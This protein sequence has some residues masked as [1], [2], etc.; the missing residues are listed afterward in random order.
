MGAGMGNINFDNSQFQQIAQQQAQQNLQETQSAQ[1]N[2]KGAL[3]S[4]KNTKA[5]EHANAGNI[6]ETRAKNKTQKTASSSKTQKTKKSSKSSRSSSASGIAGM[7]KDAVSKATLPG[8]AAVSQS[9]DHLPDQ[10]STPLLQL[11][12]TNVDGTS[13]KNNMGTLALLGLVLTMLA[14]A[15]GKTWS[16]DFLEQNQA[17]QNQVKLAP[18]IGAAIRAQANEQAAATEAQAKQSL[19]SGITNICSFAAAGILGSI[20][21]A[22]ELGGKLGSAVFKEEGVAEEGEEAGEGAAAAATRN[23]EKNA[24][25]EGEELSSLEQEVSQKGSTS[26]EV[27]QQGVRNVMKDQENLEDDLGED[28]ENAGS[29]QEAIDNAINTPGWQQKFFRGLSVLKNQAGRGTEAMMK[30]LDHSMKVSSLL[31]MLNQG[32]DGIAGSIYQTQAAVHQK[33]AG[34]YEAQAAELQQ[35]ASVDDK[36]AGQAASLQEQAQSSFSN[37]LQILQNASDSMTQTSASIFG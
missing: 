8:I 28:I 29:N 13:L 23:L 33:Q 25:S 1:Q 18:E 14:E 35:M 16:S 37:A 2:V 21:A 36:M 9:P 26:E 17:I 22:S 7:Q 34:V 20:G 32:I 10:Y 11:A 5:V 27:T 30:F 15:N 31:N 19:I 6:D 4:G 12:T 3:T 24:T